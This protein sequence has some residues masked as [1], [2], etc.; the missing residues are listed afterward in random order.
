MSVAELYDL[1]F[2]VVADLDRIFEF[3]LTASFAIVVGSHFV[4]NTI[5]R[6]QAVLM[7]STYVLLSVFLAIR[8]MTSFNRMT[9]TQARLVALGES[10]SLGATQAAGLVGLLVCLVGFLGV[11][12]F[13]WQAYRESPK[14]RRL[15]NQ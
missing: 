8:Y 6:G 2:V 13:V 4:T 10:P 14:G 9:E 3:W 5:T 7:A 11:L 1:L 15:E 12:S